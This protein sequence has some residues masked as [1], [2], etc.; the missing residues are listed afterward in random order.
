MLPGG[1]VTEA[2]ERREMKHATT[3][4]PVLKLSEISTRAESY[5]PYLTASNGGAL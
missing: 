3:M 4:L 5:P 2:H 1:G